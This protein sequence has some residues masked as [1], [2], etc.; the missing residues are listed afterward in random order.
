M[1]PAEI[2]NQSAEMNWSTLWV[3]ILAGS[4]ALIGAIIGAAL[5][6][7]N[8]HR[9]WLR[10]EKADAYRHYLETVALP[11]PKVFLEILGRGESDE[12]PEVDRI[13]DFVA[14]NYSAAMRV[15]LIAPA[16]INDEINAH[17]GRMGSLADWSNSLPEILGEKHFHIDQSEEEREAATAKLSAEAFQLLQEKLSEYVS[18]SIEHSNKVASDMR[19]DLRVRDYLPWGRIKWLLRRKRKTS[20]PRR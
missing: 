7:N 19:Q 3:P 12:K 8:E 13:L 15:M 11:A 5:T 17:L 10:N 4:F 2:A 9:Q 14:A 20:L 16:N 18:E 6:R 1:T